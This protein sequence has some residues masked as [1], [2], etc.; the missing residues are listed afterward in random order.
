MEVLRE[1]RDQKQYYLKK[2]PMPVASGIY[3]K[4]TNIKRY[5]TMTDIT[6][7]VVIIGM[8]LKKI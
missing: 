4:C 3:P 1:I 7:S 2:R 6:T 5:N 8:F